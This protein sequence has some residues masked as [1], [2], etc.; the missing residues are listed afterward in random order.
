MPDIFQSNQSAIGGASGSNGTS[1]TAGTD[2]SYP[3]GSG[4]GASY[5]TCLA[6]IKWHTATP[7]AG[8]KGGPYVHSSL[9]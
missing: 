9:L 6:S 5:G 2:T 7:G 1:G 3:G 4:Q 8:G